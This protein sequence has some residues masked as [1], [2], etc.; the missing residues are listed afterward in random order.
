MPCWREFGKR[1]D[2]QEPKL[3]MSLNRRHLPVFIQLWKP[4][5]KYLY[6][7]ATGLNTFVHITLL[8]NLHYRNRFMKQQNNRRNLYV[9]AA[10]CTVMAGILLSSCTENKPREIPDTP[11]TKELGNIN[12]RISKDRA[13]AMLRSFDQN[14]D[15]LLSGRF[16]GDSLI[17]PISETFNLRA[18]DSLLAQ[19]GIAGMRAYLSMDPATRRMRLIL[20]G[21]NGNGKDVLEDSR[22]GRQVLK[23]VDDSL[24]IILDESHRI[25]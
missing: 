15:S 11:F 9:L 19:P 7:T 25:P 16:R 13:L 17:L 6:E 2:G 14:A 24:G 22:Q 5:Y 10:V 23:G 21:V 20:V 4:A 18:I 3:I 1:W 12:H 8:L